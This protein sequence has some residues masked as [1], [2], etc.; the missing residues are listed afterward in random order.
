M[1]FDI[2]DILTYSL[3]VTDTEGNQIGTH[4]LYSKHYGY[5]YFS[6]LISKILTNQKY[7]N[8]FPSNY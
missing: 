1:I 3:Q 2:L 5:K 8:P 6:P 4:Q 7:I